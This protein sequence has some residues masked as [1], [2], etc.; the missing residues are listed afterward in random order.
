MMRNKRKRVY[1]KRKSINFSLEIHKKVIIFLLDVSS[2]Q[3]S[4]VVLHSF[5][6]ASVFRVSAG[7]KRKRKKKQKKKILNS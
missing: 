4:V 2:P 1:G 3:N 6:N 7:T 5:E